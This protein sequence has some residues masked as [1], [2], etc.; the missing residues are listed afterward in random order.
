MNREMYMKSRGLPAAKR[1][2]NEIAA[3][4]GKLQMRQLEEELSEQFG[5][6]LL[7]QIE[8]DIDSAFG[9]GMEEAEYR[10][11]VIRADEAASRKDAFLK[12]YLSDEAK[13]MTKEQREL[14]ALK[15]FAGVDVTVMSCTS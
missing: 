13:A 1:I 2:R 8:N 12:A 11:I 6:S 5:R 3:A 7:E 9:F 10:A 4:L 14:Y 15:A